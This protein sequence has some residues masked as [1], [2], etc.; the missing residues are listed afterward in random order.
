MSASALDALQG[1]LRA[2]I[3]EGRPNPAQEEPLG[4]T[5]RLV[6]ALLDPAA[7]AAVLR[8]SIWLAGFGSQNGG[9]GAQHVKCD[10]EH[11]VMLQNQLCLHDEQVM[12]GDPTKTLA[13]EKEGV[14]Y[15]LRDDDF[16]AAEA[17]YLSVFDPDRSAH[18]NLLLHHNGMYARRGLA[19]EG[20]NAILDVE[21]LNG[22]LKTAIS[23]QEAELEA[24]REGARREPYRRALLELKLSRGAAYARFSSISLASLADRCDKKNCGG[25][26]MVMRDC[27]EIRALVGGEFVFGDGVSKKKTTAEEVCERLFPEAHAGLMADISTI[28]FLHFGQVF[29]YRNFVASDA[30]MPRLLIIHR[31]GV[32]LRQSANLRACGEWANKA[33]VYDVDVVRKMFLWRYPPPAETRVFEPPQWAASRVPIAELAER[34]SDPRIIAEVMRDATEVHPLVRGEFIPLEAFVGPGSTYLNQAERLA[35]SEDC[36]ETLR[37]WSRSISPEENNARNGLMPR[38]TIVHIRGRIIFESTSGSGR[39]EV[40]VFD[41]AVVRRLLEAAIESR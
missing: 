41:L 6:E 39:E 27:V 19:A 11:L 12:P 33:A 30:N 9:W 38:K 34:V 35:D 25:T 21:R 15:Y 7:R 23:A 5:R 32:F 24:A 18:K 8:A 1:A 26:D 40:N 31:A 2:K 16:R 29:D 22:L 4:E 10:E 37:L 36:G 28:K 17:L 14:R 13:G 3:M 20:R